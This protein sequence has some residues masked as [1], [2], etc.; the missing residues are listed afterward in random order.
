MCP[1]PTNCNTSGYSPFQNFHNAPA[2]KSLQYPKLN[3]DFLPQF[4]DKSWVKMRVCCHTIVW[5]RHYRPREVSKTPPERGR[6]KIRER[7][8]ER[9]WR[10]VER[11]MTISWLSYAGPNYFQP[12]VYWAPAIVTSIPPPNNELKCFLDTRK[13]SRLLSGS[14]W[15][16]ESKDV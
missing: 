5:L 15:P 2:V 8:I 6:G 11:E 4:T 16:T 3:T 10:K 7:E 13:K 9:G 14:S 12:Q 1:P